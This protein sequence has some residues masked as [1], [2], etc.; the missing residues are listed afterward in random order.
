M[1]ERCLQL[2]EITALNSQAVSQLAEAAKNLALH[3]PHSD[4]AVKAI[5]GRLEDLAKLPEEAKVSGETNT[6]EPTP[7]PED[8]RKTDRRMPP[9]IR[10]LR[11]LFAAMGMRVDIVDL[12]DPKL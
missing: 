11:D 12:N 4:A 2:A 8:A 9:E 1:C 10:Q 5:L 7:A 6:A 3:V